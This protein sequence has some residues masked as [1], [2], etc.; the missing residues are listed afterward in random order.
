MDYFSVDA[1][2]ILDIETPKSID[3]LFPLLLSDLFS[4]IP[5]N[6]DAATQAQRNKE[7]FKLSAFQ[8]FEIDSILLTPQYVKPGEQ[9]KCVIKLKSNSNIEHFP[10]VF[11]KV[12]NQVHMAAKSFDGP[13]FEAAWVG[14]EG[15]Q[16]PVKIALNSN[17][18]KYLEGI[19]TENSQDAE[20][21]VQL[22]LKWPDGK[23][24]ENFI[25]SY[26]VD[27][28]P[29]YAELK[30]KGRQYNGVVTFNDEAKIIPYL[31]EK[32]PINH[33][34]ISIKNEE[35]KTILS[36]ESD[37]QLPKHF[38][39]KGRSGKNIQVNDGLYKVILKIWDRANNVWQ[40][41]AQIAYYATP[42]KPK[43][44]A[45]QHD[46]SWSISLENENSFQS[47]Y[48]RMELWT[49]DHQLIS[50]HEGEKLPSTIDI[51]IP[52]ELDES[53]ISCNLTMRDELGNKVNHNFTDL[54]SLLPTD[55]PIE[56]T[57][58]RQNDWIEDF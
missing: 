13:Y 18:P 54:T 38:S 58:P 29:P 50:Q 10:K 5:D 35:G 51:V 41:E 21:D 55:S 3:D 4:D 2:K 32:E 34:Q 40:A 15:I 17:D 9:V 26:R 19:W 44:Y 28:T 36:Q 47:N 8:Q 25:G 24:Q 49:D 52:S 27:N 31:K 12:G 37:Q 46:T 22:V 30:I 39:W 43:V 45:V 7:Y 48:W 20:Y 16:Q 56:Q 53:R 1:E 11:F 14:S 42:P 33:W 57:V 23:Q 6:F